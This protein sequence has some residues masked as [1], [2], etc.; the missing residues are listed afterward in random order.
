M[1]GDHKKS[2]KFSYWQAALQL[3]FFEANISQKLL[4][5]AIFNAAAT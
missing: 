2:R 5:R 4:I 1:K 3:S